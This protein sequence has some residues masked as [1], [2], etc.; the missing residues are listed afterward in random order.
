MKRLV[1]F[2]AAL[3]L[4]I[5]G[6]AADWPIF[7]GDRGLTGIAQGKLP[8]KLSLLW[9]FDATKLFSPELVIETKYPPLFSQV[10]C[11]SFHKAD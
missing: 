1:L 9:K 7:R 2:G 8:A 4:G 3:L 6:Y 10:F 5:S 11:A